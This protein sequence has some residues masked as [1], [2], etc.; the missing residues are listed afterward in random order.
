M[1]KGDAAG[2]KVKPLRDA[3]GHVEIATVFLITHDGRS[4][5]RHVGAELVLAAG[6]RLQRDP[7]KAFSDLND[8]NKR[9]QKALERMV[10]EQANGLREGLRSKFILLNGV[11]YL[12]EILPIADATALKNLAVELERETGNALIAFGSVSADD[13]PSLTIKISDNL[14]KEKG[15]NAG[16]IVRE[17]AQKFLKGGGGG[18][19]GFATA[20][21]TEASG[22]KEALEGVREYLG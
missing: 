19:P 21:G 17:L 9:L 13:K 8:E 22:L 12:A 4:D 16:T 14:V 6:D 5:M 18:Q 20:G 2:M 11:N 3:F 1:R 7:G 10:Q 15:L